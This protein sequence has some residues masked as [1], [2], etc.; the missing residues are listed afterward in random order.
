M[1]YAQLQ[2]ALYHG[3]KENNGGR[4]GFYPPERGK[5]RGRVTDEEPAL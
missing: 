2:W 5:N 4:K 3:E 1:H